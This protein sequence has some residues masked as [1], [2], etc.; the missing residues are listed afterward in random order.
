MHIAKNEEALDDERIV[1]AE[2]SVPVD[3]YFHCVGNATHG[4]DHDNNLG[5]GGD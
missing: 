5:V 2:S 3:I 4:K 1:L